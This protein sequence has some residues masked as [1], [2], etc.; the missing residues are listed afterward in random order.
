[1]TPRAADTNPNA[2]RSSLGSVRPVLKAYEQVAEQLRELMMT[3]DLAPGQRL[4]SEAALAVEFGVS[5]ATVR[6][7]LRILSSQNLIRTTKGATGG[8]FVTIPTVDHVSEFMSANINLLSQTDHVSLDEFLEARELLE[9]PAAR[10]AARRGDPELITE[11]E[12]AIPDQPLKL[13]KDQQFLHNKNFHSALVLGSGNS[14]LSIAAQ[15]IF[16]VLQTHLKRSEL[17]AKYHRTINSDHRAIVAAI[18]AGDEDAVEDEMRKH[19]AYLRPMYERAWR[20][21]RRP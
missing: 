8:S 9:V 12:A 5:R 16:S 13:A 1:M 7:A 14:L 19:L 10:L 18:E 4:P 3:G 17:G 11:L 15:P 21:A 6:E 2:G 20:A